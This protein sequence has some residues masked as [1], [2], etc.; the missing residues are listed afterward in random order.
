MHCFVERLLFD[1]EFVE[2]FDVFG[3]FF[4]DFDLDFI[5]NATVE[6]NDRIPEL[7]LENG[8]RSLFSC[9]TR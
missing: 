1:N 7:N 2:G 3:I 4:I 9:K 8:F 5:L 6:F